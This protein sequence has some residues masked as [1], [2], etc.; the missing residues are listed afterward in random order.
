MYVNEKKLNTL[1]QQIHSN[2]QQLVLEKDSIK[3]VEV[4][5][6]CGVSTSKVSKMVRKLGF[7][8]FKHYKLFYQGLTDS[9][10]R[11][12]STE[13]ERLLTYLQHFDSSLVD[14]FVSLFMRYNRIVLYGLGPSF[15]CLEYFSYKLETVSS[16]NI[17]LA[18]EQERALQ[19]VDHETLLIAF[20]V[21]GKFMSFNELFDQ[22]KEKGAEVL[23]VLEE[24]NPQALEKAD[25]IFFLT[26]NQQVPERLPYEKTR[27]IF[28]IFIEEVF[29]Q[30]LHEKKA[31]QVKDPLQQ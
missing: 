20:S 24:Y 5:E 4:A 25:H 8:S 17:I 2:L 21:T 15:I 19:L 14:Q 31:N 16:K 28:F 6:L 12:T 23:F 26:N 10:S 18:Q 30:L 13:I 1:E 7:E 3:I 11:K 9:S 27:T 29:T 22:A